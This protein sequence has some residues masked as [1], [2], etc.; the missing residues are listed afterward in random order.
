MHH[1]QRKAEV[2]IN[3]TG[4]GA[5]SL[6]GVADC[7]VYPA[8]GQIV[9]VRNTSD[10]I[11]T[12]SGTDDASTEAMYIMERAG[13]GGTILG[14]CYQNHEWE[15][16][17]DPNLALR[18]MKRCVESFP[19]LTDGEGI[20]GLDIIRHAVG[21][22]PAREGGPRLD[23]EMIGDC[24]VIHNYG[25]GGAGYQWSYGCANRVLAILEPYMAMKALL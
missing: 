18:I 6:G 25:H 14:G 12:V 23:G 20:G 19:A 15:S 2:I 1:T 21:L 22:R 24:Y 13:G 9:L 4:L 11:C 5:R 3:C 10:S 7:R 17:P 16:Q 8:R